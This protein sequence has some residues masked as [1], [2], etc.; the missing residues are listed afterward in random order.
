LWVLFCLGR[1]DRVKIAGLENEK[2]ATGYRRQATGN[3][4][5]H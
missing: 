4:I 3:N 5:N 1:K 2:K